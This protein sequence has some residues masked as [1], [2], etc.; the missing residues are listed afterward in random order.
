MGKTINVPGI[1]QVSVTGCWAS[2]TLMLLR[3]RKVN[4][5]DAMK[6]DD[7]A[8]DVGLSLDKCQ[9]IIVALTKYNMYD[10]TD[11][12]A[13]VPEF[14]DIKD[15]IDNGNPIVE[16]V[17][18]TNVPHGSDV[19]DAHYIIIVGY[20]ETPQ[21]LVILDPAEGCVRTVDYHAGKV[22]LNSY[23]K[24]LFWGMPIFTCPP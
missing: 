6:E 17:S 22:F 12:D 1:Q 15:E 24:H 9:N 13:V 2:C 11:D 21:K 20:E 14:K 16:C 23:K 4:N 3:Y 19:I 5:A 10:S 7:V 8:K 18:E